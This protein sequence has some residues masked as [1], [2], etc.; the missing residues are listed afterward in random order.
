MRYIV[1]DAP[2]DSLE[3][4]LRDN[5]N[6]ADPGA[7]WDA[8]DTRELREKLWTLQSGLCAYCERTIEIGPGKT[9]ID[10]IIPK[11][12]DSRVTFQYT[13]LVLC[14]LDKNTCNLHKKGKHFAGCDD[15][16]RFR[17]GFIAPTQQR[18]ESSFSYKRDGSVEASATA[19]QDD[20][21]ETLTILNL[22][23]PN[24]KTERGNYLKSIEQA[25][26]SMG[27]QFDAIAAYLQEE[28]SI[29]GG[30]PFFSAKR[31]NFQYEAE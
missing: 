4:A 12:S 10:H 31:Q 5:P 13:N 6:P 28:L 29:G 20:A 19:I 7:A 25:I 17:Q 16:G 9:S 3:Q 15:T 22:N 23:S 24:L 8:F 11:S 27:E 14:C 2:P 18:C 26:V 30:K 1:H 21:R